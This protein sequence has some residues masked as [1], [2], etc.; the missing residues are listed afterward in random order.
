[1]LDFIAAEA[2]PE[3]ADIVVVKS[4]S[5]IDPRRMPLYAAVLMRHLLT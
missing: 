2:A 3:L 1:M 5:D 4:G